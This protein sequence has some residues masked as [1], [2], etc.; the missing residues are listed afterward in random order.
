MCVSDLIMKHSKGILITVEVYYNS[1]YDSTQKH[2][3]V[4]CPNFCINVDILLKEYAKN[5]FQV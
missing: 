2:K 3:A 1:I 5:V 4:L